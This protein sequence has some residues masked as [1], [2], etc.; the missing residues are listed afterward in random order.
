MRNQEFTRLYTFWEDIFNMCM[1]CHSAC[2]NKGMQWYSNN[3]TYPCRE[4]NKIPNNLS[5]PA[6]EWIGAYMQVY[7][8]VKRNKKISHLMLMNFIF[9]GKMT[10]NVF[11]GIREPLFRNWRCQYLLPFPKFPVSVNTYHQCSCE[12][13]LT[14]S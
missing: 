8:E 9:R 12:S 6:S 5:L 7:Y 10:T 13:L 2:D 3:S 1:L 14:C 4:V 11:T